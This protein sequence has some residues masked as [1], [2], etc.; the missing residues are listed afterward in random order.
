VLVNRSS[1]TSVGAVEGLVLVLI[2]LAVVAIVGLGVIGAD[3]TRDLGRSA[4]RSADVQLAVRELDAALIARS[5]ID[6]DILQAATGQSQS[7][8]VSA[9][10]RQIEAMRDLNAAESLLVDAD[11]GA[12]LLDGFR[13]MAASMNEFMATAVA[14]TG[15]IAARPTGTPDHLAHLHTASLELDARLA[16]FSGAL[17]AGNEAARGSTRASVDAANTRMIF[18]TLVS[19]AVVLGIAVVITRRI[20]ASFA[21]KAAAEAATSDATEQLVEQIIRQEFAGD[22]R[23]ALENADDESAALGVV[24]LALQRTGYDGTAELLLADSS[25]AHLQRVVSTGPAS[26]CQVGSPWEC[27]AVRRGRTLVFE[28]SDALR[29]CPH[30]R[31]REGGE[32]SATCTPLLFN[33]RGIG[34]VHAFGDAGQPVSSLNESQMATIASETST[35]IGT[36]RVLAK[37][38]FQAKTDGLTGM[39]NRRSLE[40]TLRDLTAVGEPYTLVM[41]DLDHFKLLNDTY[42]H[43]A[44]DRALR[45][46]SRVTHEVLRGDDRAG[47]YGGEEFVFVFPHLS[48]DDAIVILQRFRAALRSA[49]EAGACPDFTA[50]FGVAEWRPNMT[51]DTLLRRADARLLKAKAAGRDCMVATDIDEPISVP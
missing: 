41:V 24:E 25:R 3:A 11:A 50:S 47:R 16:E 32:L 42:G 13:N 19:V 26:G 21:E 44:G 30:L 4:E 22:L 29:A 28:S 46:F 37:N 17:R 18:A 20:K 14:L 39:L 45:V 9:A 31:D 2:A 27:P 1:P 15:E 36:I 8:E 43:E 51:A 40:E 6:T 10:R 35:R 23:E 7:A 49:T 34:V 12:E 38:Q 48:K 5:G 33:G